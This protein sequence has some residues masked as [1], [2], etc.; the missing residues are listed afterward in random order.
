MGREGRE[1]DWDTELG[2]GSYGTVSLAK[3]PL[4][5]IAAYR[6]ID[7]NSIKPQG[8]VACSLFWWRWGDAPVGLLPAAVK[9]QVPKQGKG[10]HRQEFSLSL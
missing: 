10:S 1:R 5:P 9:R 7:H 8:K 3:T 6:A 4:P 2:L